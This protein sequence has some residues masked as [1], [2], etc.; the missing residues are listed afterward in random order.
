[1]SKSEQKRICVQSECAVRDELRSQLDIK[2][3][4]IKELEKQR[5]Y[6]EQSHLMTLKE[7]NGLHEELQKHK[8]ALL[9]AVSELESWNHQTMDEETRLKTVK[10]R[11]IVGESR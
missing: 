8:D 3:K 2:D 5:D 9:E 11:K 1:V 6:F 7:I 4:R 10:Y